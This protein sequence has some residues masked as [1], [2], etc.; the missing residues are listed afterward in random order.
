MDGRVKGTWAKAERSGGTSQKSAEKRSRQRS[1][2]QQ[3]SDTKSKCRGER[4]LMDDLVGSE[5]GD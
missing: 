4:E 1:H 3:G 5:R 2:Q